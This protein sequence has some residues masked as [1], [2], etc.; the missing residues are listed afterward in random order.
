MNNLLCFTWSTET[1][2][3]RGL[4]PQ[5][6]NS[7][8]LTDSVILPMWLLGGGSCTQLTYGQKN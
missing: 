5:R 3:S 8:L 1:W 4:R 7:L 2:K 6:P